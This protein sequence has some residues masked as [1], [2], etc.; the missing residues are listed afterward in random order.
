MRKH[1]VI[2]ELKYIVT[3][4]KQCLLAKPWTLNKTVK[5]KKKKDSERVCI[6]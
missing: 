4:K 3:L 6:S 2:I 1:T 5:G